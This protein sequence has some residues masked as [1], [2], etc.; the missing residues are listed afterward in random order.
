MRILIH[1]D[2]Y[3]PSSGPCANRMKVFAEVLTQKG[4][5]IQVLASSTNRVFGSQLSMPYK[6]RYAPA[7]GV[8]KKTAFNRLMNNLSFAVS[9][10]FVSLTM[11]KCDIVITTSPPP[12]ISMAGWLCQ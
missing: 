3:L 9:S 10:F 6:I 1:T 5:Q 11:D 2:E 7:F 12:L 8:K 4:H